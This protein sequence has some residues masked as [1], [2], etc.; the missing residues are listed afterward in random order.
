MKFVAS[1]IHKGFVS[2]YDVMMVYQVPGY[3][4]YDVL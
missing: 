3:P 4:D 1:G 2:V